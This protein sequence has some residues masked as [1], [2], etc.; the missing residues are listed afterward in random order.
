M[1]KKYTTRDAGIKALVENY[2][3]TGKLPNINLK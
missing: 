2:K 1:G 3:N